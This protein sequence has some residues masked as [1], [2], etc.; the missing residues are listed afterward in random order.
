MKFSKLGPGIGKIIT[1]REDCPHSFTNSWRRYP[2]IRV[3]FLIGIN[4][5]R[6]SNFRHVLNAISRF[7]CRV[8]RSRLFIYAY[9]NTSTVVSRMIKFANCRYSL[10][11]YFSIEQKKCSLKFSR[12]RD[13]IRRVDNSIVSFSPPNTT[14]TL[15][16]ENKKKKKI[17]ILIFVRV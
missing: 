16:Y 15:W 9:V 1:I 4:R 7:A 11:F 6:K 8:Y 2:L 13:F 17:L 5:T 14:R 3:T 10:E 12:T